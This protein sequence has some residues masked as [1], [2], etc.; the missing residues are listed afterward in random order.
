MAVVYQ[1]GDGAQRVSV[2][3]TLIEEETGRWVD[4]ITWDE[5]QE[6]KAQIGRQD[7]WAVEIHPPTDE[8]VDV[9]NMRHLW[10][11]DEAP[12]YGWRRGVCLSRD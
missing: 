1:S 7:A 6:I 12:A 9:A 11:L 5:L 10:L 4:G 3:R 2:N 8:V